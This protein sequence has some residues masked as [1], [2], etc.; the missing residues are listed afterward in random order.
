VT[1]TGDNRT[2]DG[3]G[4]DEQVVVQLD[5]IPAAVQKIAITVTIHDA[6]TRRQSFGQVSNA[7]IRIVNDETQREVARFD[8]TEDSSTET[9]M[10]FAELYR[11]GSEWK[12]RAVGQGWQGGLKAMCDN[13]GLNID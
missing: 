12:L 10:I 8:L 3:D 13:Y 2:G 4:D 5:R 9:A 11:Y 6:Q 7:F 1:H